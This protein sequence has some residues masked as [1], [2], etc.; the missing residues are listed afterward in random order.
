M[1]SSNR[2][3]ALAVIVTAAGAVSLGATVPAYALSPA[4]NTQTQYLAG[5][6]DSS[7]SESCVT[8]SIYLDAGNYGW[9]LI[10]T[11]EGTTGRT[12]YLEA[13]TYG[14]ADCLIP[15]NG[16]YVHNSALTPPAGA[17]ALVSNNTFLGGSGTYTWGSELIPS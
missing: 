8:R 6:P 11:N 3:K 1:I 2:L 9:D 10:M 5:S 14:W 15:E 12:I 4:Y 13:G 16:Y 7:M 17:T